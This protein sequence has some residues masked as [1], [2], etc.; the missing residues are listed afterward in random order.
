MD[1]FFL[2]QRIAIGKYKAQISASGK[3]RDS[4]HIDK[5]LG[6]VSEEHTLFGK[7][8]AEAVLRE[9]QRN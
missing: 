9:Q 3:I 4:R 8:D 2:C 7:P 6:S 5:I 1:G